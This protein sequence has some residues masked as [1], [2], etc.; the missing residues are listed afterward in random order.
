MKG[1]V[2]NKRMNNEAVPEPVFSLVEATPEQ[3]EDIFRIQKVTWLATYQNDEIGITSEMIEERFR[4][5]EGRVHKWRESIEGGQS[6]IWLVKADDVAVGFCA[7]KKGEN[8]NRLA[9]IYVDPNQQGRGVGGRLIEQALQYLGRDKD[10]ILDVVSYN[11]GAIGFYS[12][13]GFEVM[14]E[15]PD[16]DLLKIGNIKLPEKRMVLKAIE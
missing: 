2:Y 13:Y 9:A 12:K 10:I 6:K 4:D 5:A 16:E 7:V 1:F 8:N 15:V 14:G 11:D 3:V